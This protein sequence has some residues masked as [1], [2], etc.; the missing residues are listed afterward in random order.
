MRLALLD[1]YQC[2]AESVADW[3]RLPEGVELSVFHDRVADP[4]ALVERLRPFELVMV[5]RERTLVTRAL[6]ERL[7]NLQL[8]VNSGMR[9]PGIDV[10]AATEL[11]ILVCGTPTAGESPAQHTWAL[12]FGL[13]RH[14]VEED[15]GIRGGHWGSTLGMDLTG[16]TMGL[17]G[18]GHIGSQT[19][20]IANAFGMR[21]VAWSENL[22]DER[23]AA[24]GVERADKDEL[25]RRSDVVSLHL[26][27]SERTRGVVGARELGL[28]KPTA[29]LVNTA[30]GPLVN[31][32][33]LIE[34][35]SER[36]IAGAGLDVFDDEPL[37]RDHPLLAL[38]NTLLT[39]HIGYVTDV[40]YRAYYEGVIDRVEAFVAGSPT[41]VLN[42][43][44]LTCR[45]LRVRLG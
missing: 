45:A 25:F 24:H 38:P 13:V 37:P 43:E 10:A 40:S 5:M 41:D 27:L 33:A 30:R 6:L 4:D 26:R 36:R 22:T 18:L 32:D 29:V 21:V 15:Q 17:L 20:V 9:A 19:A 2:V 11:G 7:P 8:L 42:P 44:V 1:D 39:P 35:L 3:S 28:M 14:L 23:A 34:A 16:K 31:E 12:L